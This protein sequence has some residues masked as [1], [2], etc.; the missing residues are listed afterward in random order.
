MKRRLETDPRTC[1][2]LRNVPCL[3]GSG[4][5]YKKCCW[6]KYNTTEQMTP[7]GARVMLKDMRYQ[8]KQTMKES[9]VCPEMR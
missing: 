6:S 4:K 3:C 1:N 7:A 8:M 9:G 5:K 2:Q